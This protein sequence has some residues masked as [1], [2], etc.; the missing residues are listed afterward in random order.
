MMSSVI[1]KSIIVLIIPHFQ[2]GRSLYEQNAIHNISIS[3]Y[4]IIC[5]HKNKS[6]MM[7]I[8]KKTNSR[9]M[10]M[11]CKLLKRHFVRITIKVDT[12]SLFLYP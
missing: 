5:T 11:T 1:R 2:D 3:S 8:L 7:S 6:D 10:K 4:I 9:R 12:Y